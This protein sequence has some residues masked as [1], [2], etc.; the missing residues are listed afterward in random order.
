M[1]NDSG[2][3]AYTCLRRRRGA[4][5]GNDSLAVAAQSG[6]EARREDKLQRGKGGCQQMNK[7][8]ERMKQLLRRAPN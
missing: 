8:N 3:P 7:V 2:S 1:G 6:T 5:E 4:H